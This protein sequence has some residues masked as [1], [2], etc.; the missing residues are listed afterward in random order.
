MLSLV[1]PGDLPVVL[2]LVSCGGR[3]DRGGLRGPTVD[4]RNPALPIN[5]N[6]P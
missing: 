3:P 5:R 2:P 4:D 6:I 1:G